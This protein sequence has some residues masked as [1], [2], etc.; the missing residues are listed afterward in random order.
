MTCRRFCIAL[1]AALLA[2]PAA[3]QSPLPAK[4]PADKLDGPPI[5]SAKAWAIADGKTGEFLWGSREND[6]LTMASTTKIMTARLVF[7]LSAQDPK[8]LDELVDVSERAAKT[9]GTSAKLE[10]GDRFKAR[11]LL[12]GLLLPSGNDAAVALA[13]HFGRH[14]LEKDTKPSNAANF[15]AFVA[16]MNREAKSLKLSETKYDDPHGNSR[17]HSSARNLTVLAWHCLQDKL[18]REYVATRQHTCEAISHDGEKKSVTWDNT[19]R[20]LG[21]E[22]FDGVKTGTTTTAGACLVA[23]GTRGEDRLIVVVLGSTSTDGRYV[24]S[25]NLFRWAWRERAKQ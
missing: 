14:F 24:D 23:T 6:P 7:K 20:L 4:A 18:F 22:G 5:V 12:F 2:W 25:R 10:V 11:D 13:E 21:I 9:G 1:F 17:N 15:T 19:N 16:E 3:A 8:L